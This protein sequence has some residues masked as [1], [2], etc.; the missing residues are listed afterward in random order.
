MDPIDVQVLSSQPTQRR[1][2]RSDHVLTVAS[3]RVDLTVA[4]FQGVLRSDDEVLAIGTDQRSRE[5]LGI[6]VGVRSVE[7]VVA[8]LDE[9]VKDGGALSRRFALLVW[10]THR[11]H[12]ELR[13]AQTSTTEGQVSH[14]RKRWTPR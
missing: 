6:T 5:V 7:K 13:Q 4:P 2:E 12:S 14:L 1:L 8:R 3:G 9:C 11:S 10:Q